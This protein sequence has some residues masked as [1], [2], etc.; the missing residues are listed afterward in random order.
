M[1]SRSTSPQG[2]RNTPMLQA[3]DLRSLAGVVINLACMSPTASQQASLNKS[4][5]YIQAT[6]S[7]E[8]NQLLML[9]L[10]GGQPTIHDVVARMRSRW[11]E[12]PH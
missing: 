1:L 3:E 5:A 4:L 11:I 12:P 10:S 7:P 8:L 6:F 9:L 2:A